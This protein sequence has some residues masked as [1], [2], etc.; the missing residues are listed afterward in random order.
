MK[1]NAKNWLKTFNNVMITNRKQTNENV[2]TLYL[3]DE[4]IADICA[5]K[6]MNLVKEHYE[7]VTALEHS[8]FLKCGVLRRS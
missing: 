6:N 3:L 4:N 7:N 2:H 5:M 1:Q 8:K